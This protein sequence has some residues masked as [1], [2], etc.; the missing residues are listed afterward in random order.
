MRLMITLMI[1]TSFFICYSRYL[2]SQNSTPSSLP[3]L[4]LSFFLYFLLLFVLPTL[5]LTYTTTTPTTQQYTPLPLSLSLCLSKIYTYNTLQLKVSLLISP[6][7]LHVFSLCFILHQQHHFSPFHFPPIAMLFPLSFLSNSINIVA[8]SCQ[9]AR[10]LL[11]LFQKFETIVVCF[12][13]TL[14]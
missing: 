11:A 8:Y 12:F 4:S 1:V 2:P 14:P 3:S 13:H 5:T 7:Q 9:L 6:S 10:L